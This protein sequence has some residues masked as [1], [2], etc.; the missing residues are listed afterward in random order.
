MKKQTF[1][2][3]ELLVVIAI[4]AILASM[5]LPALNRARDTAL[6]ASC[7]NLLKQ[8]GLADNFYSNEST[9]Y[10]CASRCQGINWF[11]MMSAYA[12]SSFS[13]KS[14][15]DGT[16][17]V[18]CVPL[19]TAAEKEAGT[20]PN[21]VSDRGDGFFRPWA[22]DG[23]FDWSAPGMGSY[24]MWQYWGYQSSATSSI[25]QPFIK[26]NRVVGPSHKVRLMESYYY[27][28]FSYSTYWDN[29]SKPMLVW[30]RHGYDFVANSL[31]FDGH[32]EPLKHIPSSALIG[33]QTSESY[34]LIP[35]R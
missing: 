16:V 35:N 19:C 1:T 32:V 33:T 8:V 18:G 3:I 10:V 2:L 24:G 20:N 34:Y 14:K 12:P 27:T 5:L 4:I 23:S 15:K 6:K 9:E 21:C 26:S 13:R 7:V 29:L 25:G 11:T 17:K 28:P 30:K 22:T 31:M